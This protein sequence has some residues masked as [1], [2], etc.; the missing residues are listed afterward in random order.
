MHSPGPSLARIEAVRDPLK[1]PRQ[2]RSTASKRRTS[3]TSG[4][5]VRSSL[6]STLM[7]TSGHASNS[8]SRR[9]TVWSLSEPSA[10]RSRA[11]RTSA[12]V[13]EATAPRRSV[14]RSSVSSWS[15][16]ST[17]SEVSWASVSR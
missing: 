1:L 7:R 5:T 6:A 10:L 11:P 16:T 9:G 8:S 2:T 4:S 15:T 12:H 14:V 13:M 17:P 3:A